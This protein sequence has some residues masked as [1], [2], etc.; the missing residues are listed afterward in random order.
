MIAEL[1][2]DILSLQHESILFLGL[3]YVLHRK[4]G[5]NKVP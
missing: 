4:K 1:A 3:S 5:T 2:Y